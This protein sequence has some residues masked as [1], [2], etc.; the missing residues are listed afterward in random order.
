VVSRRRIAKAFL[1]PPHIALR[2]TFGD[3]TLDGDA[4]RL[5]LGETEVPLSPK[6]FQ[7]LELLLRER[8]RALSKAEIRDHLWPRMAVADSSLTNL[9]TR[10]RHALADPARKP[11]LLR[12]V[13]GFGYAFCGVAS[14]DA[15]RPPAGGSPRFSLRWSGREVALREGENILGV[16]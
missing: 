5:L 12:T 1:N 4:R 2:A 8:P 16:R 11:E 7:L 6:A 15:P 13:Q 9:V 10:L 14:E 3:F